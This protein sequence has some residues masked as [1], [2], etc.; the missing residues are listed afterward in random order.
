MGSQCASSVSVLFTSTARTAFARGRPTVSKPLSVSLAQSS[1]AYYPH[2]PHV[3]PAPGASALL[4]LSSLPRA[5][6]GPVPAILTVTSAAS[7]L[8]YGKTVLAVRN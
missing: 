6:K 1:L 8:Y 3:P 4:L 7:A 2:Q 5:A